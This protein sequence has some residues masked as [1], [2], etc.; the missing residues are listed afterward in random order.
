MRMCQKNVKEGV[1]RKEAMVGIVNACYQQEKF[2]DP[3]T[4]CASVWP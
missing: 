1:L 3:M 2:F 4:K